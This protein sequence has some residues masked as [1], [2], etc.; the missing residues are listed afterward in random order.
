MKVDAPS[1]LIKTP[2]QITRFRRIKLRCPQG[3]QSFSVLIFDVGFQ[4]LFFEFNR[5]CQL[6]QE[7]P[8][9]SGK[10]SSSSSEWATMGPKV[11]EG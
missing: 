10:T 1:A 7:W 11:E 4:F 9:P 6:G 2:T 5:S 3:L 8:F